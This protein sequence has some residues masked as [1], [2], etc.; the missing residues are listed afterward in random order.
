MWSNHSRV[1]HDQRD[2]FRQINYTKL[3]RSNVS[4]YDKLEAVGNDKD[5]HRCIHHD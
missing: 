5:D 4:F 1:D 3:V 2:V